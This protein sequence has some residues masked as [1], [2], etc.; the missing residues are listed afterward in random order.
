MDR[1]IVVVLLLSS[2][3]VSCYDS[4]DPIEST[5]SQAVV[6]NT[7]ISH[8]HTLYSYGTRQ[9]YQD[10]IVEGVVTANDEYGNFFK[11]FIIEEDGYAIEILDGLY[12]SYVRH[13][14]GSRVALKLNGLGLD[15]YLGVLRAGLVAPATS[16]Y[17]LDYMTSEAV[18]DLY[19]EINEFGDPLT[20]Q[21]CSIDELEQSRAGQ[22][23]T[24]SSLQLHT[25]DGVERS[26]S[27][28]ALFRNS[29]LDS[30]WC[31]TSPYADFAASIIPQGDV[32]LS[33]IVEFGSTD[34]YT[35]QFILKLRGSA[36][37]IY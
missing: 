26:W 9:I 6:A 21:L 32:T 30:I 15:R 23:V 24:L 18:V 29:D 12:D 22:L 16:S 8:V 10:L 31:Y 7:D 13:P 3:A 2:L 25:E 19:V 28:Y 36:D 5:A 37:C 35:N 1:Q 4:F 11:S 14:V 33:G 34:S 20:P 27:G 17:T